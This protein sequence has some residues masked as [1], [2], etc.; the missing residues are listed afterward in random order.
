MK[1]IAKLIF[2][3]GFLLLSHFCFAQSATALRINEVLVINE[4]D[5]QDDFGEQEAWVEIYNTSGA[6][7]N[8]GGCFLTDDRNDPMKY[9]IPK[10]DVLTQI[11]PRQHILFWVDNKPYR[12]TFHVNFKFNP[13]TSNYIA[14]YDSNGRTLI[15]SIT[16]PVLAPDVSYGLLEDGVRFVKRKDASGS[17]VIVE[18]TAILSRTSPST[19]NFLKDQ[20]AANRRLLEND[21]DGFGMA[22]TAMLVVFV[23]LIVLY[24]VFRSIGHYHVKKSKRNALKAQ[25]LPADKVKKSTVIPS[26]ESGE[27]YAAIA[28]ALYLYQNEIHDEESTILTIDKVTRNYSPWSSKIYAL[29]QTP[30]VNKK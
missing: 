6:T 29:R 3:A 16:I 22:A 17:K 26:E 18:A 1:K 5:F 7:V 20:D 21:P 4:K 13:E 14:L 23:A 15:D 27:V 24:T 12:G 2:V 10:G 30:T 8:I 19:N 28:Y 11:K 9:P 25:G